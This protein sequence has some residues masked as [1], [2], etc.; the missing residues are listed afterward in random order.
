M[1]T[2]NR[3]ADDTRPA[4]EPA[5]PADPTDTEHPAGDEQAQDNEDNESPS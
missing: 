4:D 3:S 1:S 5:A 2:G